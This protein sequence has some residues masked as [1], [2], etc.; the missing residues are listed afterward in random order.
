LVGLF[1]FLP[2]IL[3][4]LREPVVTQ[5]PLGKKPERL[6]ETT[7]KVVYTGNFLDFTTVR[8]IWPVLRNCYFSI[9]SYFRQRFFVTPYSLAN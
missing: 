2:V 6:S 7:E 5:S 3:L 8:D 1:S 4:F 9:E